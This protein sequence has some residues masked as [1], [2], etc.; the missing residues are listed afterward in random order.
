MQAHKMKYKHLI[1]TYTQIVLL[2]QL[3]SG[4]ALK[5]PKFAECHKNWQGKHFSKI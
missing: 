2:R 4:Q 3:L 5:L 1:N